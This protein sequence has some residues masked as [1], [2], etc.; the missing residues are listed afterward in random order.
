MQGKIIKGIAGF[1]YVHDGVSKVY[2]CK[3]AIHTNAGRKA[4]FEK[5]SE[6]PW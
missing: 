4:F 3:A 5:I 6:S 1:Y 2:E